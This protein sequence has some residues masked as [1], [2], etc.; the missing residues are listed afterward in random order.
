MTDQTTANH[1][2]DTTQPPIDGSVHKFALTPLKYHLIFWPIVIAGIA[3]DLWTKSAIFDWLVHSGHSTYTVIQGFF[4]LVLAQNEG[5]AFGIAAG[6]RYLL[7]T[8]SCVALILILLIFFFG[9]IKQK[10]LIVA[11]AMFTAGICGN[12]YDRLFNDG[13][14]RDFIDIVYWS[15]KHWP[16][17]N[18]A[19]SL[20][21]IAMVL[22][23]IA[24][25][26]EPS[27][28]KHDSQQK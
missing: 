13:C 12:L 6:Q 16:A 17:F 4:R 14:V 28:Q 18:I 7:T 21:C 23:L 27:D 9:R 3:A 19:D 25:L 11:L 5:A 15:G 10:L 2:N 8:V 20:L 24:S 1:E 26:T 22:I